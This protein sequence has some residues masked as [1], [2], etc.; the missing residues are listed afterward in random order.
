MSGCVLRY[1]HQEIDGRWY[2]DKLERGWVPPMELA[3]MT[4]DI[5]VGPISAVAFSLEFFRQNLDLNAIPPIHDWQSVEL[6]SAMVGGRFYPLRKGPILPYAGGG[7][8]RSSLSVDWIEYEGG[9][10]PLFRC[11]AFCDNTT[12]RSGKLFSTYHPYAAAGVEVRLPGVQPAFLFEYRRDFDRTD[13][14]YD[15]SGRSFSAGM[16]FQ[17]R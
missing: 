1:S 2:D 11:I 12:D 6:G 16:R 14:F 7:Y 3:V 5:E 8:G 9:F 17:I 15:L 13:G 4:N 10:D